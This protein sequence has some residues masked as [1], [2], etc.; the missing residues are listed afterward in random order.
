MDSRQHHNNHDR[1]RH[2]RRRRRRCLLHCLF[3]RNW[4][5]LQLNKTKKKKKMTRRKKQQHC[6][7]LPYWVVTFQEPYV[8]PPLVL[9]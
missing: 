4:N 5:L 8:S 1:R 7:H 6:P 9:L 2:S 3:L